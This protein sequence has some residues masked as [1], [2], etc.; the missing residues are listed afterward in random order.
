MKKK[1]TLSFLVFFTT[2]CSFLF[3]Q[4]I[5]VSGQ[6]TDASSVPLPGV[7]IQVKGTS[8]GTSS[9]FDGNYKIS[10]KQGDVLLFSFLGFTTNEA[11]VT[12][13]TLNVKLEESA[14]ILGE[15]IVTAF[16]IEKKEKS[17]GYSVTQV[18]TEDLNLTGNTNPISALQGRVAGLQISNPSGTAGGGFD[19]L[20]RGMSSMNPSQNNQPLIVLDGV[21]LNNDT[22]S[23]DILPSAGSNASGS[24]EQ[25]SFASRIGDLNPD[26]IETFN[27]LKGTAATALYGMEGANGVIV[28]TTKK[29]KQGKPKISLSLS[30]TM[31]N[32]TKAPE[33]QTEFRQGI[34]GETNTLYFPDSETGYSFISGTSS[35]GPYNFGVRYSEDSVLQDGVTLDLS[36]DKFYDPY[37]LF[38]TGINKNINFGISG[39][40]EKLD[41]YF[42]AAN[43]KTD[44]LIPYTDFKKTAL[45]FK[46]GY[47]VTVNLKINSSVMFTKSDSRKPTGGDKSIISAL[48]YWSPT[49]PINDFLNADGSA[50]N[51]YPGW[52][53][54][55]KYN[56]YISGL[57]E[58]TNR[59]LGSINLNWSPIDWVNVNY[60]A[61]IDNYTT[62]LNRFVPPELDTGSQVNG[63]IVDQNYDFTGL[64]SNLI[65]TLDHDISE[66]LSGSVLIGNSVKDNTR[67]SYRMYGQNLNI[68]HFNHISNTQENYSISNYTSQTRLIGLF[69][70]FKLDYDDKL[71]LS[72]TGRNDWNSTLPE[73]NNSYF[74][75]SVSLAYDV[76]SLFNNKDIFSYGKLRVSYAQVG[77][78]TSFGQVGSYFYPDANFPWAGT[79]GYIADKTIAD[80]NLKPEMTKGWEYGA[81]FRF[82]KNKLRVDYAYFKNKV[83]DAIFPASTAPSTGVTSLLRN[84]GLYET[85]G[86]ELLIS[87]DIVKSNDL[88]IDLTYNF[89]K[90]NGKIVDLPEEVPYINFSTDLTG[91][92]LYLQPREGDDI[93]SIYGYLFDRTDNGELILDAAGLP[94]TTITDENRVIVGDATPDFIMSLGSNIKWKNFGL[95][96][97]F[98]WKKG[99]DKYSWQRYILNRMGQSEF[100]RQ[101]RDGDGQYLFD[102]VMEDPNNAGTYIPNTTVAD[103]SP[104]S[105]S[106]Y[107][108]FNWTG[109]GRRNAEYLLQDASWVKLRSLGVT[110]SLNKS[111]LDKLHLSEFVISAN[112]NNILIWTPFDGFDPEGSDYSAGSNKYG[113]TG[114]GIP[115]A[116]NYSIGVTIGF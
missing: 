29:G 84:S 97:L 77:N 92:Y 58:D 111:F 102:G 17:L 89:A 27:V 81:D 5:T 20:I 11:T 79:G 93:G 35:S 101:F 74:Y 14:D 1:A 31:S 49:F 71:F 6:V 115:L 104:E 83:Y 3:A 43:S 13:T 110:Y 8:N 94:T 46:A 21:T 106:A 62:Y 116:E 60:T 34:Y 96:F 98:E 26:D 114:R 82:F 19:I 103:F 41:Y 56:A 45:R 66:K 22:F 32:V 70:E 54:N 4:N 16:G 76:Q 48:G 24:N 105:T 90:S 87:G 12:G 57:T 42:S 47:Q 44:G 108:L 95:N 63:F 15:V 85:S 109:Y 59:W 88:N 40:S 78:G 53:D 39:A 86:H 33:L 37:E 7:N 50:R 52:I 64:E 18:K 80:P 112:A 28:I 36:N 55:P 69:G 99:G 30:T 91:A 2:T 73:D 61:Q 65:V 100:S 10:A 67:R 107:R 9:D 23:G 51:P 75:P 72:V 38:E 68:P 113:F 25:F